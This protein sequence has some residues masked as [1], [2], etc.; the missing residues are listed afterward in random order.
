MSSAETRRRVA[1]LIS[2]RGSNMSALVAAC[3]NPSF[4]GR[5]VGVISNR[6]DA[7]GIE[8]AARY[9]IP[10][11]IVDHRDFASREEHDEAVKAEL[12]G[13]G[14]EIVCLAGYMRL[15]T[16][17]FV[18]HF[19]G[20]MINIHPSLLPLFPGLDTHKRALNAG[21]RVHGC[22]VHFVTEGMD[23]GPIIAQAAIGV[24]PDDTAE[25]LAERLLRAE[26]R[27]YPHALEMLLRGRARLTNGRV[28]I[29][30]PAATPDDDPTRLSDGPAILVSPEAR[31]A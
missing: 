15:L 4:P 22:T 18:R 20:R 9:D 12:E 26:H 16:P 2:G 17:D 21:M 27:L 24:Q 14:A 30:M 31:R 3:M 13:L 7:K 19:S 10:T 6:P 8:T 29:S 11:R 5:I 25:T 28:A 1:I 23:E